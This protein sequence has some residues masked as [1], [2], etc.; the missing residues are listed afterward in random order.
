LERPRRNWHRVRCF[1]CRSRLPP[2]SR[3]S[4]EEQ[5][6]DPSCTPQAASPRFVGAWF[7]SRAPTI[8]AAIAFYTMFSL[9]PMLVIVIAVAGRLV[10]RNCKN[11]RSGQRGS[12]SGDVEERRQHAVG[13]HRHRG[14]YQHVNRHRHCRVQRITGGSK[15]DLEVPATGNL[16]VTQF[17]KSRILS[18]A[19]CVGV[20][21]CAKPVRRVSL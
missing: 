17:L 15:P 19:E 3:V 12:R 11:R 9:A 20:N 14:R 1:R 16:S 5:P 8:G 13:D 2:Q 6:D 4:W 18:L 21:I 10:R 7:E